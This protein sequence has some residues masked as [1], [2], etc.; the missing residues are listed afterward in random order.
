M[1]S[2]AALLQSVMDD[3]L[4]CQ[5]ESSPEFASRR[6]GAY[7]PLGGFIEGG[8]PTTDAALDAVAQIA[9]R[10]R[11]NDPA[12]ERAVSR[13]EWRMAVSHCLGRNLDDLLRE[14]DLRAR[15]T[16]LRA[17]LQRSAAALGLDLM[18]HV[19]AWVFIGQEAA[20]FVVG[21]VEFVPRTAW[22]D[23]VA[24][25][26]GADPPW[27]APLKRIWAERRVPKG[28]VVA[29][30]RSLL[31]AVRRRQLRPS[32]V[33]RTFSGGR[34]FSLPEN[35][36]NARS[37]ASLIH[38]DQW[39]ACAHVTG[40]SRDESNRRGLLAAR[41]ALDT[42]R[43]TIQRGHR[44]LLS[45][46]ADS[47]PPL[48]VN[49]LSQLPNRDVSRR[50]RI[51]RPGVSG[52]PGLAAQ[53]IASGA[54]LFAAAGRCIDAATEVT[55]THKCP[56]LAERWFNA[57]HWFG[58]ACLADAD[59]TAVVMLVISLDVLSGGL[60]EKGIVELIARLVDIPASQQVLPGMNLRQLVARMYK[61]RSEVA[62]GSVLAV[63]G[64]LDVERGQLEDLAAIAI[65][66]YALRL[67][68][69]AAGGGSDDRDDF[70]NSL[71][72]FR[73]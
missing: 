42:V 54:G 19:P 58:R 46:A 11:K 26:M 33:A 17:D 25:R 56:E 2:Y 38:H 71:P 70:R 53:I 29:G 37:L 50:W 45:T 67:D 43:L 10:F 47:V 35:V 36:A 39:V 6:S 4:A 28:P 48:A 69:Y 30:L 44:H 64:Q 24:L 1:T 41:V 15:W 68:S 62:H 20:P 61:L 23:Q 27:R 21:P 34:D 55:P 32:T 7:P 66:E 14:P 18:H 72:A 31:D 16:A 63:H 51:N 49:G 40:F 8:Y 3:T 5:D 9:D 60:M 59:F 22:P 13:D 65:A 52:P 73:P 57:C 12:L